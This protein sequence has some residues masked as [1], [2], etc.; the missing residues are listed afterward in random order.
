MVATWE[1]VVALSSVVT[2]SMS[3]TSTVGG[4]IKAL[5]MDSTT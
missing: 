5:V 4:A 3:F 2:R 1:T